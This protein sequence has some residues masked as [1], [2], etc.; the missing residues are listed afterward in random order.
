[1]TAQKEPEFTLA[2]ANNLL[3]LAQS[4]PLA[5]MNAARQVDQLLVRAQAFFAKHL[6]AQGTTEKKP[7]KKGGKSG[8]PIPP[9]GQ[10]KAGQDPLA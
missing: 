6:G 2:D 8:I 4:A 1:M 10:E 5:N 7:E 9:V 3:G